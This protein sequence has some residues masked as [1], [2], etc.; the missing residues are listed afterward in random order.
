M[1]FERV[2]GG[3]LLSNSVLLI[4]RSSGARVELVV[5]LEPSQPT[6]SLLFGKPGKPIDILKNIKE[7]KLTL[8][9]H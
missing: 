2:L 4:G 3:E 7:I 9:F 8:K 1:C 5:V 6:A